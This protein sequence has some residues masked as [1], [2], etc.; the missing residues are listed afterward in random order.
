[1]D[2]AVQDPAVCCHC[3]F[4]VGWQCYCWRIDAEYFYW[5][6]SLDDGGTP[7]ETDADEL[8]I[9]SFPS[10]ILRSAVMAFNCEIWRGI[11]N[12]VS[13]AGPLW[14]LTAL[15]EVSGV[16]RVAATALS[17]ERAEHAWALQCDL[18]AERQE[19][20]E[21]AERQADVDAFFDTWSVDSDG[22][23]HERYERYDAFDF[24]Q[25]PSEGVFMPPMTFRFPIFDGLENRTRRLEL[26]IPANW[27]RNPEL[28]DV[29]V[30]GRPLMDPGG[31]LALP[32]LLEMQRQ[33]EDTPPWLAALQD[34]D[35]PP[36]AFL[37]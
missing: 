21:D 11:F 2:A 18:L 17:F 7:M 30:E 9:Q 16:C 32:A 6:S 28:T 12:F 1:M 34:R 15:V 24:E 26:S 25:A 8:I 29:L 31:G 37:G 35:A 3:P 4:C 36:L 33:R 27:L 13:A 10:Q 14:S 5:A 22:N 23:W 19:D 20:E